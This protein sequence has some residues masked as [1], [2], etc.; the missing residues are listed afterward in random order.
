MKIIRI[1]NTLMSAI[2]L[3][4]QIGRL[5]G[6]WFKFVLTVGILILLFFI[7]VYYMDIDLSSFLQNI[8]F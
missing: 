6:L 3:V 5:K 4:R 8:P 7:A 1:M 2:R